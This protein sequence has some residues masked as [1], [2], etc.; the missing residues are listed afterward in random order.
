MEGLWEGGTFVSVDLF[1]V[2]TSDIEYSIY[3]YIN[4]YY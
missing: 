2:L 3:I 1:I 4:N